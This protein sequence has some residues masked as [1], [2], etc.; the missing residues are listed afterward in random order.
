MVA[1]STI[2]SSHHIMTTLAWPLCHRRMVTQRHATS[3]NTN[4][5]TNAHTSISTSINTSI[6]TNTYTDSLMTPL[7]LVTRCTP[8][9]PASADPPLTRPCA[10][11]MH[12]TRY[13]T[14]GGEGPS[15]ICG[16]LED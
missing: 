3:T 1:R 10:L 14:D 11:L 6:N 7:L 8:I 15:W 4:T 13:L 2:H 5:S 12:D 9:H 16:G